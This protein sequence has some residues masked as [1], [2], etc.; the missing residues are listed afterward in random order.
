MA[1]LDLFRKTRPRPPRF[2]YAVVGLGHIAGYFIDALNDSPIAAV[3]ALVSADRAKAEKLARKHGIPH[4]YTYAEFDQLRYNDA[5]AAVYLALPVHLHP[6]YTERAAAAGKHVLCE[7]PMAPNAEDARAMIAAC[8]QAGVRLSIAYRCPFDPTHQRARELV[9]G[10]ALGPAATLRIESGYCFELHPGWRDN[11]AD[12]GGGSLYDVGIYPLNAARYLLGEDP[13][14]VQDAVAVID[15]QGLERDLRWT[16]L[17]PS[18]ATAVCHSSYNV[19]VK[20]TLRIT[21]ARGTLLLDPAF[22]HRGRLRLQADYTDVSGKSIHLDESP[23]IPS[24]FRLEAEGLAAA[25]IHGEPLLT[26]GEDGLAD[27]VAMQAIYAAAG[28]PSV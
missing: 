7:K 23:R 10:G 22:T 1:L 26:P 16:S 12:A 15:G 19:Q 18:G 3:T 14:A 9:R 13:I 17:F 25:V 6:A 24:H 8:K 21:G 20:D 2:G 11:P 4:V 28:V 5:V 27:M